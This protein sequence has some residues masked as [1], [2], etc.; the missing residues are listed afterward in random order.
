M[1]YGERVRGFEIRVA[2]TAERESLTI[3]IWTTRFKEVSSGVA[4]ADWVSVAI[5]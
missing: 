2:C 3:G 5:A 4:G 1:L